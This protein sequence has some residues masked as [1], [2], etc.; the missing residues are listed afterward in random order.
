MND[1]KF[2]DDPLKKATDESYLKFEKNIIKFLN[3]KLAEFCHYMFFL[4]EY[5]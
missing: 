2:N 1:F 3:L 5:K 4:V